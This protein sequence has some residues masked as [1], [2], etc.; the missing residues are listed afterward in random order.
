MDRLLLNAMAKKV[1][2]GDGKISGIA[3]SE[4]VENNAFHLRLHWPTNEVTSTERKSPWIM[5]GARDTDSRIGHDISRR[6]CVVRKAVARI[7][8][9]IHLMISPADGK[10]LRQFAR[11]GAKLANIVNPAAFLHQ[12]D[13][14]PRFKC[15]NQNEAVRV[16][17]HQHVQHPMHAIVE[18]DV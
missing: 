12:F 4:R 9:E 18:I 14:P 13:P 5:R 1:A 6:M 10:R 15:T 2:V 3:A 11:P 17:F 16:A 7:G 8:A